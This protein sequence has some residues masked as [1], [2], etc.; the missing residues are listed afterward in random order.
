MIYQIDTGSTIQAFRSMAIVHILLASF[1]RKPSWTRTLK[2]VEIPN[3][4][5]IILART[6]I[7]VVHLDLTVHTTISLRARALESRC[8]V[9][10]RSVLAWFLRTGYRFVLTVP[11]SPTGPAVTAIVSIVRVLDACAS[12]QTGFF[13]AAADR[14]VTIGA[15]KSGRTDA[16]I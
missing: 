4:R 14:Y 11:T 12:V 7:A 6:R 1:A 8:C 16:R 3:A 13:F 5:S 2:R 9:M 15:S 10:A